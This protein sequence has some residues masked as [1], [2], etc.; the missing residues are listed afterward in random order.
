MRSDTNS[1][2]LHEMIQGLPQG[3]L[4]TIRVIGVFLAIVTCAISCSFSNAQ[5][6]SPSKGESAALS[7]DKQWEYKCVEYAVVECRPQIVKA[8]TTEVVVDLDQELTVSGS[9]SPD[10]QILWAPDSKR[11]ASNYSPIHAHHTT[12]ETVAFYQ[13]RNDKWVALSSPVDEASQQAQVVQLAKDHLP[14]SVNPPR[15]CAPDRDVLKLR[16]WTDA[17]TATLYA[18]CYGRTSGQLDAAFLFT[19]KFDE[20]G[21]WK[22]VKGY[23]MSQREVEQLEKEQ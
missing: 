4:V 12:F 10:A 7:P 18:P 16:N 9:D 14:K 8:G 17:K 19:L 15:H 2:N 20:D 3:L 13:L 23:R 22:I 1:T 6:P 21:N 11:F 5:E